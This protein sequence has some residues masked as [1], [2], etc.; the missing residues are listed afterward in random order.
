MLID[1]V[2]VL[3]KVIAAL[4]KLGIL[5]VIGGSYASSAHGI[6]RATMDIDI[7]AAIRPEH[8][9]AFA[10]ELEPEFYADEQAIRR[11]TSMKRSFNVIHI[12]TGF[13]ADI[14]VAKS[15]SFDEKQLERRQLEIIDDAQQRTAY[16]TTAEDIILAKLRWYRLTDET[17]EQQWRDVIGVMEVQGGRL[18]KGY[19]EY[20]AQEL[21]VADLLEQA[22]VDAEKSG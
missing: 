9:S 17:S 21:G 19:L 14:F 1:Q 15:S 18:D 4:E 13:K 6:V 5:Y 7:L 16:V 3:L 8:A 11:A 10:A 2:S 22:F 20:W 12:E